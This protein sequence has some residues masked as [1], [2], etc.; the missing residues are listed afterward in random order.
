MK[1]ANGNE[2]IIERAISYIMQLFAANAGGH[3]AGI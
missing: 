2:E 3:D 1:N